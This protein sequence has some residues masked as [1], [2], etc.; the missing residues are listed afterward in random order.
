MSSCLQG[1]YSARQ[2]YSHTDI[3]DLID[4]AADRAIRVVPEFD[5]PGRYS[6]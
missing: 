6:E 4:Y 1:A 2:V 5:S 3:L